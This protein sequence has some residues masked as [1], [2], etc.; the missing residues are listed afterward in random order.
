[1]IKYIRCQAD[2]S[3]INWGKGVS[4][5]DAYLQKSSPA[6][7]VVV[8]DEVE[9]IDDGKL[10][11]DF[12]SMLIIRR[13]GVEGDVLGEGVRVLELIKESS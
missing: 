10:A 13:Y 5:H 4:L 1:M 2:G 11:V 3:I 8:F 9:F 12:N 6:E 7:R